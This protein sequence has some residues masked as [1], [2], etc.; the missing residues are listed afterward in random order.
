MGARVALSLSVAGCIGLAFLF[1][2][3]K[4]VGPRDRVYVDQYGPTRSELM[5]ADADG[6]NPHKLV[7]GTQLDYNASFSSDGQWVVF[8]SDRFGNSD[9]FRVRL[10]GSGLERLTDSP[11]YE[12]QA[13]LSPDNQSVAFVSTRDQ[14]SADI[15]I[16]D[17]K[18]RKVRNLTNAPRGD[19]RPS[20]SPD[21]KTIAFSSDRGTGFPH[22]GS[23]WEHL[24]AAS[25]YTI[26]VDGTGL[27]KL[28]SDPEMTSGSPKWS[29]DGKQLVFYEMPVKDT[30]T[31]R[32]NAN[33]GDARIV[34]LDL[35]TG[36]RTV[37]VEM[38]GL[39]LSPQFVGPNRIAYLSRRARVATIMFTTG[40]KGAPTDMFQPAWSP[41]GKKVVYHAGQLE[42]MHS[43]TRLPGSRVLNHDPRFQLEFASSFPTV[44]PDGKMIAV[45]E[46]TPDND[47]SA[48]TVWDTTGANPRR[49]YQ[50]QMTVMG[51]DWSRD[52]R[53]AFGAGG[54]FDLRLNTPARIMIVQPDGS[55]LKAATS[56]EGNAGFPS[57]SPDGK[58]IV[59]RF[60]TEGQSQ[61]LK[62]VN[63]ATGAVRT[64][65]SGYD[66]LPVWSPKG[67][68]IAFN[69]MAPDPRFKYD[70][71]DIWS[72]HPD[73][74]GLK[75]LTDSEGNDA[76]PAW[77][78]D[79]RYILWS[80]SRYGYR[81]EAP[82]TVNQPQPY[83]ELFVMNADGSNQQRL[84]DNQYEDGTPAW[85]PPV[86]LQSR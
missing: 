86:R 45:S 44:S 57:W 84:T 70:E 24:Q 36:A 42:T 69:R 20:W 41:D 59:Y 21:G 68:V 79:G 13:A 25:I 63:V 27:R 39:N 61:G 80:S 15:Y 34:T 18:T 37:R 76:H 29:P 82:L 32:S 48:L 43:Y 52:G 17:L 71:F 14:G 30:Y 62:I 7:P 28:T 85:V 51:L 22:S 35:A 65:S 8:T 58:E 73:G 19:F 64:L 67:D 56:G 6:K 2:E 11:A 16:L 53:I 1:A 12:D 3:D 31:V 5:I 49:I 77:S 60:W 47:R 26:N 81:D 10:D 4:P 40:E 38:K 33:L 9:I 50:D 66:T 23:R 46:R 74:T 55:G 75:R 54:F 78:P 83:A 72:I